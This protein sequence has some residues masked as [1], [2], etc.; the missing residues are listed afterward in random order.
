MFRL[1]IP[2][3]P[4]VVPRIPNRRRARTL[5]YERDLSPLLHRA[6]DPPVEEP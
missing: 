4:D 5:C 1:I 3:G 6:V 2:S